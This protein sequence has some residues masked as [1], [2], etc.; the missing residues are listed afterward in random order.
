MLIDYFNKKH[1]ISPL[2]ISLLLTKAKN[3]PLD[4]ASKL[5]KY[6]KMPEQTV[7]EALNDISG[8]KYECLNNFRNM[9]NFTEINKRLVQKVNGL[10]FG[11]QDGSFQVALLDPTETARAKARQVLNRPIQEIKCIKYSLM[12]KLIDFQKQHML[13][14]VLQDEFEVEQQDILRLIIIDAINMDATDVHIQTVWDAQ[15]KDYVGTV[16]FRSRPDLYLWDKQLFTPEDILFIKKAIYDVSGGNSADGNRT[17]GHKF[18]SS[19]GFPNHDF[20]VSVDSFPLRRPQAMS[21]EETTRVNIGY[22]LTIRIQEMAKTA[23]NMEELNLGKF[24]TNGLKRAMEIKNGI[25][26]HTG[27]TG[28]GKNTTTAGEV[29]YI[30]SKERRIF[31][32]LGNPIEYRLPI[33]QINVSSYEE[34]KQRMQST[35]TH[36][37]DGII[38]TE[39]RDA[40]MGHLIKESVISR[41]MVISTLHITRVWDFLEKYREYFGEQDYKTMLSYTIAVCHQIMFRGLCDCKIPLPFEKMSPMEKMIYHD[42]KLEGHTVYTANHVDCKTGKC[43][44]LDGYTTERFPVAELLL[45]DPKEEKSMSLLNTLHSVDSMRTMRKV[46]KDYMINNGYSVEYRVRE[47]LINGQID[48]RKVIEESATEK[49]KEV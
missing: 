44:C 24:V 48:F 9:N 21:S 7:V 23:L 38:V 45:F 42:L 2:H 12:R 16:E 1:L 14:N 18:N 36:D 15:L 35:K 4:E 26:M 34:M 20:R 30:L 5:M 13:G 49:I 41:I 39:F 29:N 32:E 10:V 46:V 8:E 31:I 40:A 25:I 22:K 17:E 19:L 11:E 33:T 3:D 47:L 43:T 37:P 6:L 28:S 27:G